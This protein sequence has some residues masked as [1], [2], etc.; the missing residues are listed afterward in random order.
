MEGMLLN[1]GFILNSV[2]HV[3]RSLVILMIC[4]I[5]KKT[6][7][8]FKELCNIKMKLLKK[9]PVNGTVN[10]TSSIFLQYL[11]VR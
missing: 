5:K 11:H 10:E 9:K 8:T 4:Y 1:W 2:T 3:K 6:F 7:V